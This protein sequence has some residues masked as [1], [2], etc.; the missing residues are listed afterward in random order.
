M[1]ELWLILRWSGEGGWQ[2]ID[3]DFYLD[4]TAAQS[5]ADLLH[6]LTGYVYRIA[7]YSVQQAACEYAA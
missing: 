4:P 3:Y 1:T 5:E 6:S 7:M 2:A